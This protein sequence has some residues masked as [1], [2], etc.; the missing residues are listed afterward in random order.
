MTRPSLSRASLAA[1][2]ALCALLSLLLVVLAVDVV[3]SHEALASGD[4]RYASSPAAAG[5]WRP[6]ATGGSRVTARVLG[7]DD[8]LGFREAVRAL[9]L[10]QRDRPTDSSPEAILRR[11]KAQ[12]L[13]QQVV[14]DDADPRRRSR[15]LN[16]LGVLLLS[17]PAADREER[18]ATQ[19][20]A[21]ASLQ[22]AIMADPT[23]DTAK[24]NLE[25]LL[26]RRAGTQTVQGGPTPNPSSGQGQSRGAATGRPGRGY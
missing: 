18:A 10:S 8:D 6:G 16:L 22:Q 12:K 15:A 26:R 21:Q 20:L 1:S 2:A 24:F 25:L 3:R 11:A 13:L 17:T 9:R 4:R 5:L 7:I 23:N 19:R 14:R